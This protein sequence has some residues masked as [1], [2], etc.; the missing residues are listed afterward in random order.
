MPYCFEVDDKLVAEC[1]GISARALAAVSAGD[2]EALKVV[3]EDR[4]KLGELFVGIVA[5]VQ[6][7]E[8]TRN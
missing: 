7:S 5:A 3:M 4:R 2:L 6:S 8:E 1:A